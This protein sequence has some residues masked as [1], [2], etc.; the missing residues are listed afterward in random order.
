MTA[1][2]ENA[3]MICNTLLAAINNANHLK[4]TQYI[5][6]NIKI[7]IIFDG[8]A[9]IAPDT[10]RL[11][12]L[13]G[14]NLDV[15]REDDAYP[16]LMLDEK[17]LSLSDIHH[18]YKTDIDKVPF[19]DAE[20]KVSCILALKSK[21]RGKLDSHAWMFLSL[22]NRI[23][24]T[25]ILQVDAGT[26][27]DSSC[28]MNL[29]HDMEYQENYA[30]VAAYLLPKPEP[31]SA[32]HK[33]WQY[34]NFVWD[35]ISFWPV[36]YFLG[37]LEV[38]PGACSLIRWEAISKNDCDPTSP[39]FGYFR[40]LSPDGLLQKNLYLAEDRVLG[41]EIIKNNAQEYKLGFNPNAGVEIDS[42]KTLS[43]LILQRRRWI[44]STIS[45][46]FHA[47]SQLPQILRDKNKGGGNKLKISIALYLSL[48]NTI[49]IFFMPAM[50]S[51]LNFT[52]FQH[53][54]PSTY[55]EGVAGMSLAHIAY[56]GLF[57]IW[58]LQLIFS[59]YTPLTNRYGKIIHYLFLSLIFLIVTPCLGVVFFNM[60]SFWIY[61]IA[62]FLLIFSLA[63]MIPTPSSTAHFFH[64][65]FLH[66]ILDPAIS[67]FLTTY[68]LVNYNDTSWGTKGLSN[69]DSKTNS[70][71]KLA[72]LL[73]WFITNVVISYISIGMDY[74]QRYSFFTLI[75]LYSIGRLSLCSILLLFIYSRKKDRNYSL[76]KKLVNQSN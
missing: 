1:Y 69:N 48:I 22:C 31:F 53:L 25:Y 23:N 74:S 20:H 34:S 21:N 61:T 65:T 2:N 64:W 44:N 57:S 54:F 62:A 27:P 75:S 68:A 71:L 5:N 37:Y 7:C 66:L 12:A 55:I 70:I 18:A 15:I 45:A 36:G 3:S 17:A 29:L 73:L 10:L 6:Y 38:I 76:N 51:V 30:A 9:N 52:V 16:M 32:L 40:G 13:L 58:G 67:F 24:P 63:T 19:P 28:L 50:F 59:S 4:S 33:S 14:Y 42:C 72:F 43:E 41:F 39:L 11:L 35:K 8:I 60:S 49:R 46:R 56:W 26:I 47:I